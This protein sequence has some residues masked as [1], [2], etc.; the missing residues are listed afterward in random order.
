[1]GS[2]TKQTTSKGHTR[3][4][5]T[6]RKY[7]KRSASQTF[8]SRAT[9]ERWMRDK[10]RD[11]E[12]GLFNPTGAGKRRTLGM[13]I[14]H[15]I[16]DEVGRPIPGVYRMRKGERVP[17]YQYIQKAGASK[18]NLLLRW[19]DRLGDTRI[20]RITPTGIV[21][22]LDDWAVDG[23]TRNNYV[24]ALSAVYAKTAM[25]P[26]YGWATVNPCS[27]IKRRKAGERQR[28]MKQ[29]E[30]NA[31]L[32][33]AEKEAKTSMRGFRSQLFPAY[34][35]FL[36]EVGCRRSEALNLRIDDI[37]WATGKLT[38]RD[39]KNGDN[40]TAFI[41]EALAEELRDLPRIDGAQF[42]FAG[43][44]TDRPTSFDEKWPEIIAKAGI[45]PDHNGESI[46]QHTVRHTVCTEM[47]NGSATLLDLME[48]SGHKS[49]Q[50]AKR[51]IH[52]DENAVKRAQNARVAK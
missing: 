49:V 30:Y 46:G 39:T 11:I 44:F 2:I 32:A 21:D 52:T 37:S 5:A 3:Y 51:Y 26:E 41:S 13:A 8:T 24:N 28:V 14:D 29:H 42:V 17:Q 10:E 19:K 25:A 12:D 23:Q 45:V 9:A 4:K 18:H 33:I 43:R 7:G 16:H 22:A 34:F 38:F 1:M 50:T 47:A 15:H 6:V 40:R 31:I 35:K 20:D 48:A 27:T 36:Y